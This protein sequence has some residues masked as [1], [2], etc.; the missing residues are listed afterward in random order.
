MGKEREHH[1][2]AAT[3]GVPG[4]PKRKNL[5]SP[6]SAAF[7]CGNFYKNVLGL[8]KRKADGCFLLPLKIYNGHEKIRDHSQLGTLEARCDQYTAWGGEPELFWVYLEYEGGYDRLWAG[9]FDDRAPEKVNESMRSCLS[10]IPKL[11][12]T[13]Y[14]RRLLEDRDLAECW[15][16]S[17]YQFMLRRIYKKKG[18][19]SFVNAAIREFRRCGIQVN[20]PNYASAEAETHTYLE[21]TAANLMLLAMRL[22]MDIPE[23]EALLW[24]KSGNPSFMNCRDGMLEDYMQIVR[25]YP[26]Q[27]YHRLIRMRDLADACSNKY[28]AKEVGDIY[29]QGGV[30]INEDGA[31]VL[32]ER[33]PEQACDYYRRCMESEYIPAY[34][35][36]IKTGAL[37]NGLQRDKILEQACLENDPEALAWRV[38]GLLERINSSP[39][40]PPEHRLD[41][42]VEVLE[43]VLKIEDTYAEK[44]ILKNEVFACA[45]FR[46]CRSTPE[47]V[48]EK[49]REVF[50]RLYFPGIF[51]ADDEVILRERIGNYEMAQKF[52]HH[53]ANYLLGKLFRGVDDKKSREYFDAGS[54]AGCKR[55]VLEQVRLLKADE[56]ERYLDLLLGLEAEEGPGELLLEIAGELADS[57]E[58]IKQRASRLAREDNAI[59]ALIELYIQVDWGFRKMADSISSRMDRERDLAVEQTGVLN[60]CLK[61]LRPY[62]IEAMA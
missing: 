20:D 1:E 32:I 59:A 12:K 18:I 56:P 8:S 13:L 5:T 9:I 47:A 26:Y 4:R 53:G 43:T 51:T 34:I 15:I 11:R 60:Q 44:Y 30:L 41:R 2:G 7:E 28:A 3:E 21:Q 50:E 52:G 58:L 38:R 16:L 55:C 14:T 31:R 62:L 39:G 49:V 24:Y 23:G 22:S 25:S 29:R 33:E 46:H 48:P 27:S 6:E 19:S 36:A 45:L 42:F 61:D 54:N 35:A 10:D 40:E 57:V 17:V 37:K